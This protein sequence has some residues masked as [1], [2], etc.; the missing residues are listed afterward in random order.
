[1]KEKEFQHEVDPKEAIRILTESRAFFWLMI[2][3]RFNPE[4]FRKI[5]YEELFDLE[6]I[7]RI[8]FDLNS[9]LTSFGVLID[10][11]I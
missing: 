3:Y 10:T 11:E 9:L 4:L 2:K 5:S 6:T 1:M 8:F 7:M